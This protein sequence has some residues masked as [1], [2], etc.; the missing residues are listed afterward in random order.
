MLDTFNIQ[1]INVTEQCGGCR[2]DCNFLEEELRMN[3][4]IGDEITTVGG[5]TWAVV[6][7]PGCSE[8]F[9]DD[10]KVRRVDNGDLGLMSPSSITH[11]NGKPV[12]EKPEKKLYAM[13]TDGSCGYLTPGKVYECIKPECTS[14][15][16]TLNDEGG[17]IACAWKRSIHLSGADWTRLELTE[18][19][20]AEINAKVDAANADDV[21]TKPI[22]VERLA[23]DRAYWDEVAPEGAEYYGKEEPVCLECWYKMAGPGWEYMLAG[24]SNDKWENASVMP[25]QEKL[26]QR[27][28]PALNGEWRPPVGTECVATV[29]DHKS[30]RDLAPVEVKIEF[31]DDNGVF[32][33]GDDL[34]GGCIGLP[35]KM[36]SFSPIHAEKECDIDAAKA[37]D[38]TPCPDPAWNGEGLPPVGV[39]C[40]L[41]LD[42]SNRGAVTITYMGDGV[43]CYKDSNEVEATGALYCAEFSPLKTEKERVVEAVMEVAGFGE[44]MRHGLNKAFEANALRMPKGEK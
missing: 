38:S 7:M 11:I 6:E 37:D 43:F 31:I 44:N 42:G 32:M 1:Q 34:K 5:L 40:E 23:N 16:Y 13:A 14:D 26:I 41:T 8:N 19:E 15:F 25:P 27:P 39:K 28:A 17:L 4:K 30:A 9:P 36:V 22:D 3:I 21:T 35:H 12:N 24:G 2:V 10:Y 20:A 33:S 18:A 29:R